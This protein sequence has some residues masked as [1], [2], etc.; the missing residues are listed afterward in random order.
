MSTN[1]AKIASY[2]KRIGNTF[3]IM[4]YKIKEKN[5]EVQVVAEER[6]HKRWPPYYLNVQPVIVQSNFK[7]E[8][9]YSWIHNLQSSL[10]NKVQ[11]NTEFSELEKLAQHTKK[12]KG[13]MRYKFIRR[14]VGFSKIKDLKRV[15]V[16]LVAPL[17]FKEFPE[18]RIWPILIDEI[19]SKRHRAIRTLYILNLYGHQAINEM[20][21]G[22]AVLE[23]FQRTDIW[24]L[25]TPLS[26]LLGMFYPYF[27]GFH[28]CRPGIC[29]IFEFDSPKEEKVLYPANLRDLIFSGPLAKQ[30]IP[31]NLSIDEAMKKLAYRRYKH[32]KKWNLDQFNTFIRWYITAWNKTIAEWIDPCNF[33]D[34]KGNIDFISHFER[35]LTMMRICEEV[36]EIS[37]H[38]RPFIRKT[39]FFQMLDKFGTLLGNNK[40][41]ADNNFK[42]LLKTDNIIKKI[43]PLLDSLPS[44]FKKYFQEL[45]KDISKESDK[46]IWEGIWLKSRKKGY[47]VKILSYDKN[48]EKF[49]EK[50]EERAKEHYIVDMLRVLRNTYHGYISELD[51]N[52]RFARVLS[53][54]TG[55]TSDKLP[56]LSI[57]LYLSLLSSPEKFIQQNVL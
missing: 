41:D 55:D 24:N 51:N 9:T 5:G 17:F 57:I 8:E 31:V 43:T 45:A 48:K 33:T 34:G 13:K 44:L 6:Y 38:T 10:F 46:I 32:N 18:G 52:K 4:K 56:E 16:E 15:F 7:T 19:V 11:L 35:F 21:K 28:I 1:W 26:I 36:A 47:K 49:E 50:G 54:H 29:F 27:Y 22:T 53:L 3:G 23:N 39:L 40:T 37:Y 30:N 20:N 14:I 2:N 42:E 25:S 12:E